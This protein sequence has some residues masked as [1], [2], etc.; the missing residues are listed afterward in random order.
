MKVAWDRRRGY[1]RNMGMETG[2]VL[3]RCFAGRKL[4]VLWRPLR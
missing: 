2:D 3:D 1:E 4:Q